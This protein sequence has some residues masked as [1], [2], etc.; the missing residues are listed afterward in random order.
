MY[1]KARGLVF[2]HFQIKKEVFAQKHTAM[3]LKYPVPEAPHVAVYD[4]VHGNNLVPHPQRLRHPL[5]LQAARSILTA[6]PSSPL[7]AVP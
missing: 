2:H 1:F 6:G 7:V 3:G 4:G 5:L